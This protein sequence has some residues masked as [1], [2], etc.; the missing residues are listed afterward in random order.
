MTVQTGTIVS[1]VGATGLLTY[2]GIFT[3]QPKVIL[4]FA[5]NATV[6]NS[7]RTPLMLS[8]GATDGVRDAA[9]SIGLN[10]ST[11]A[12]IF[13]Q[14]NCIR[15]RN[16]SAATQA[17]ALFSSWTSADLVLNW[18]TV[19]ASNA[20]KI[21][22]IALSG[23]DL[24]NAYVDSFSFGAGSSIVRTAPG[25]QP[26]ALLVISAKTGRVGMSLGAS[27]GTGV[28][29]E[30]GQ[31][32]R[33]RNTVATRY[34]SYDDEKRLAVHAHT[35]ATP[36]QEFSLNSFDANGYTIGRDT[37][38]SNDADF[39]VISLKGANF[40]LGSFTSPATAIAAGPSGLSFQPSG[41]GLVYSQ[42]TGSPTGRVDSV[43]TGNGASDG[44]NESAL[45]HDVD[46]ST[47]ENVGVSNTKVLQL[48]TDAAVTVEEA[49]HTSLDSD[50]FKITYTTVEVSA[51]KVMWWAFNGVSGGGGSPPGAGSHVMDLIE[52]VLG[53]PDINGGQLAFYLANGATSG[54]LITA[55]REFLIARGVA[56]GSLSDMWVEFLD[57]IASLSLSGS[58]SDMKRD[59]LLASAPLA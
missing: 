1:K 57:G 10:G 37:A 28:G 11:T 50:G 55:E 35:S 36:E 2:S 4:F 15:I 8:Y 5:S 19:H 33:Y 56:A 59:W 54:N 12:Q 13:D 20:Y 18:T 45:W 25:F 29:D 44:T 7:D 22:Y 26:D 47:D 17:E 14:I 32:F 51:N 24:L 58:I 46:G 49:D 52:S 43:P 41:Y 21:N 40:D 53:G 39:I 3:E 31:G 38:D 42:V 9:R 6:F 30:W 48:R 16:Q 34:T 27:K 23:A